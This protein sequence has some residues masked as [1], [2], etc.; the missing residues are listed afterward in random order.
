MLGH[1]VYIFTGIALL[2]GGMGVLAF[3]VFH[4]R[5]QDQRD[6][7]PQSERGLGRANYDLPELA[8]SQDSSGRLYRGFPVPI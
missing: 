6:R 3:S 4:R 8:F 1:L 5:E 2:I 7:S